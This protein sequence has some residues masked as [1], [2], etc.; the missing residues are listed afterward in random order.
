MIAVVS[1]SNRPASNTRKIAA[2][3][4]EL[5]AEAGVEVRLLDLAE[6]PHDVLAPSSY[7][8]PPASFTPF[9]DAIVAASG[10]VTVV[11]EYNGSFPGVLK[12]FIDVLRFP[13]SLADKPASFVGLSSGRGGGV[14][15]VE[16]LEMVYHYRRA[17]LYGRRCFVPGI[18]RALDASGR[19]VDPDA[20]AR[21]RTMVHGFVDFVGRLRD[22]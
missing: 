21:L 10:L 15:A 9:Q 13:D 5:L 2:L 11:P 7:T 22:G 18:E 16:H 6:L 3:V 1:G 17:H 12:L 4:E 8:D 14:R 19:L 20:E